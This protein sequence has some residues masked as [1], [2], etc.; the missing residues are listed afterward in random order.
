MIIMDNEYVGCISDPKNGHG[1]GGD[2]EN[3]SRKKS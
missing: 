1:T 3:S 2:S